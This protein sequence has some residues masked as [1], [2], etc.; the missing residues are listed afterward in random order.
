MQNEPHKSDR[1]FMAILL[2]VALVVGGVLALLFIRPD[3]D[4][5][6]VIQAIFVAIS[7]ILLAIIA[8]QSKHLSDQLS[9]AA[10]ERHE[11]SETTKQT[12]ADV[13]ELKSTMDGHLSKIVEGAR[14]EGVKDTTDANQRI[15]ERVANVAAHESGVVE[16]VQEER[17]RQLLTPPLVPVVTPVDSSTVVAV[18]EPVEVTLQQKG[19]N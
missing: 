7:P 17:D 4:N 13:K 3:K 6:A 18:G 12:N 10:A 15:A 16:G 9:R 1:L 19:T 14:A 5:P 2:L 11:T 8:V